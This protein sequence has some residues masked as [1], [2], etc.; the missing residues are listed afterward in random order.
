ML[1]VLVFSDAWNITKRYN[2]KKQ[3]QTNLKII[4]RDTFFSR[5]LY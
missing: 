2:T 3:N 5:K 1:L 4:L